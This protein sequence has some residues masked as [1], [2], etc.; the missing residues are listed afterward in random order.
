MPNPEIYIQAINL[1]QMLAVTSDN[2]VGDI[3]GF[4]FYDGDEY[5][6]CDLDE[7]KIAV[8][9]WRRGGWSTVIIDE[10][11]HDAVKH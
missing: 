2:E 3:R 5:V 6:E 4:G 7:A 8:I 10:Y 11:D 9:E 1:G